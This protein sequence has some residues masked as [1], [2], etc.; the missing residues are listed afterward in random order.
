MR[1]L[2]LI[3]AMTM[4]TC[5]QAWA[6]ETYSV[7]YSAANVARFNRVRVAINK[8]TC[9]RLGLTDTCTQAEA[10]TAANAAGGAS[11]TAAQAKAANARIYGDSQPEREALFTDYAQN[12]LKAIERALLT[13]PEARQTCDW[14]TNT[15]TAQQK[16]DFCTNAGNPADCNPCP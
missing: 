5:A 7:S 6:Q 2:L 3:A 12:S 4:A 14:F 8:V 16:Q 9:N 15:A 1:K 11:C 13:E 10:C